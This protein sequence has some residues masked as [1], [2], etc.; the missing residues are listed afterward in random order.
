[1]MKLTYIHTYTLSTDARPFVGPSFS[2]IPD[3]VLCHT[4]VLYH[5]VDL[6]V[7]ACPTSKNKSSSSSGRRPRRGGGY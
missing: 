5:A 6:F 1:M 3:S 2:I 7:S 4:E